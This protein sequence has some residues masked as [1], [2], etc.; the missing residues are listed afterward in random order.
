MTAYSDLWQ[1]IA[2]QIEIW[3]CQAHS[4]NR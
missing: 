4:T 2:G 1:T 3:S